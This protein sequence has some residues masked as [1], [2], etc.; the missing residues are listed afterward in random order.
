MFLADFRYPSTPILP[1][2]CTLTITKTMNKSLVFIIIIMIMAS[3]TLAQEHDAGSDYVITLQN[4]TLYGK[5]EAKSVSILVFRVGFDQENRC[6]RA[7]LTSDGNQEISMDTSEIKEFRSDNIIYDAIIYKRKTTFLP[8]IVKGPVSLYYVGQPGIIAY[9][10]LR[11]SLLYDY[12]SFPIIIPRENNF[13]YFYSQEN[14]NM[15]SSSKPYGRSKLLDYFSDYELL[16]GLFERGELYNIARMTEIYNNWKL[17]NDAHLEFEKNLKESADLFSN[18]TAL[19]TFQNPD[20]A[21]AYFEYLQ[22]LL[23]T[24]FYIREIK[25]YEKEYE[26]GVPKRKGYKIRILKE[27]IDSDHWYPVGC[28]YSFEKDGTVKK[29][30]RFNIQGRKVE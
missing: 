18:D 23:E 2:I 4:D 8:R 7:V 16:T 9:M 17:Q 10:N 11:S 22:E 6:Y 14:G 12:Q 27:G 21:S 15:R 25:I 29:I 30:L 28:W 13:L 24:N 5:V 20:S 3:P 26:E 1:Y 19:Y